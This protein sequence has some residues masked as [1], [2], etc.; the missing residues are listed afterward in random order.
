[1][2]GKP[3]ALNAAWHKAHRMPKNPTREVRLAWH[4]E[5]ARM[6]GCRPIP[7]SL[8]DAAAARKR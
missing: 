1:M 4:L 5:H 6:C 8:R 2:T 7:G 3:S